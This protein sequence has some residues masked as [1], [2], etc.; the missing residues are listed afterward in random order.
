MTSND[1]PF[2]PSKLEMPACIWLQFGTLKVAAVV[3]TGCWLSLMSRE[4]YEKIHRTSSPNLIKKESNRS[5]IKIHDGCGGTTEIFKEVHLNVTIE[6]HPVPVKVNVVRKLIFDIVLGGEFIGSV[7]G[8]FHYGLGA[9]KWQLNDKI[10]VSNFITDRKDLNI[11][12]NDSKGMTHNNESK[13]N[14]NRHIEN[15]FSSMSVPESNPSKPSTSMSVPETESNPKPST[16]DDKNNDDETEEPEECV[17]YL[18]A[19]IAREISA[20]TKS[21]SNWRNVYVMTKEL[22]GLFEDNSMGYNGIF[23]SKGNKF[24][25]VFGTNLE[26]THIENFHLIAISKVIQTAKDNN[27]KCLRIISN[28]EFVTRVFNFALCS[29]VRKIPREKGLEFLDYRAFRYILNNADYVYPLVFEYVPNTTEVSEMRKLER[30][31]DLHITGH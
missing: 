27:W 28:N 8:I 3:S 19:K 1:E 31:I 10:I 23:W 12:H 15:F 25:V 7:K 14:S 6:N 9:F 20:T 4:M 17:D 5:D 2:D 13:S 11:N 21:I 16:S 18:E 30:L 22:V 26:G 29:G 24:N